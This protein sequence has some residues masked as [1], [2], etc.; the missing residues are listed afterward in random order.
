M[1]EGDVPVEWHELHHVLAERARTDEERAA[2][3]AVDR[4]RPGPRHGLVDEG[5][6]VDGEAAARPQRARAILP[7][8]RL[9]ALH[10]AAVIRSA[11]ITSY[12]PRASATIS[13]ASAWRIGWS[14]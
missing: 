2:D 11:R 3:G 5:R 1:G 10:A 7:E 8:S 4:F 14:M 9:E 12:S 13:C 6:P